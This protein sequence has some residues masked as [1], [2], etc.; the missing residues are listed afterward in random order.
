[1][2]KFIFFAVAVMVAGAAFATETGTD[3]AANAAYGDGW[4]TGDDGS[5]S[6]DAFGQW[7]VTATPSA[8]SYIGSVG[9]LAGDSFG[10]WADP[11][12]NSWAERTFES[13][14]EIGQTFSFVFGHSANVANGGTIGFILS[15]FEA[16]KIVF[17]F[18]GGQS[19]W[20]IYDG[21]SRFDIGQGYQANTELGFSFTYEGGHDYSYTLGSASGDH[22]TASSTLGDIDR[23]AFYSREQ[24]TGENFGFNNLA[25]AAPVPEPATMSLLGLGAL[26][27]GLRRKMR[28]KSFL[29]GSPGA[30][31]SK[32][33]RA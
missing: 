19:F 13:A 3:S 29:Q 10:L 9:G 1:M 33:K 32:E 28:K 14:M 31:S 27:L 24:G 12:E 5:D 8:G 22:Y 15:N 17:E 21:A 26:A 11:S 2:K 16:N 23:I 30:A 25:M 6:G 4:E 7:F 18:A 20:Q